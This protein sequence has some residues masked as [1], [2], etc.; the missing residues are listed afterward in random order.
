M[1]SGD[2]LRVGD[3][4]TLLPANIETT[5]TAINFGRERDRRGHA[6]ASSVDVGLADETDA[7]RGDLLA[8]APLPK[9]DQRTRRDHLLVR[10][11]APRRRPAP[12]PEAHH[13]GHARASQD[14]S[15]A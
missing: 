1:V 11:E 15:T 14:A 7:G 4:V 13:Q 2:T 6:W 5:I 12:A 10:R 8:V 3:E 9:V